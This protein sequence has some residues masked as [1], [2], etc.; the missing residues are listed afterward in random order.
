MSPS[1]CG[2]TPEATVEG[3]DSTFVGLSLPRKWRF[4]LRIAAGVTTGF[5]AQAMGEK[6]RLVRAMPVII[7]AMSGARRRARRRPREEPHV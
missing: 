5:L 4:S 3:K 6:A 2:N 1:G 7:V